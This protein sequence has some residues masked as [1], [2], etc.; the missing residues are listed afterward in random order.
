MTLSFV[1]FFFWGGRWLLFTRRNHNSVDSF[2]W[3]PL[4]SPFW[5]K[6]NI[7]HLF[8]THFLFLIL[9]DTWHGGRIINVLLLL[10]GYVNKRLWDHK[11]LYS[12]WKMPV[13]QNL[14]NLFYLCLSKT[15][16]NKYVSAYALKASIKHIIYVLQNICAYKTKVTVMTSCYGIPENTV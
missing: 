12:N 14:L 2:G 15:L 10:L 7:F 13:L 8:Y 6:R 5:S 3:L 16:E 1:R 9:C 11:P 4:W